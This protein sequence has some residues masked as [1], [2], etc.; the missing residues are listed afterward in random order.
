M[1]FEQWMEQVDMH[2]L[3]MCGCMASDLPDYAYRDA[4]DAGETP[5][6]VAAAVIEAEVL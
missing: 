5:E 4:F 6:H 2:L 1:T 3:R